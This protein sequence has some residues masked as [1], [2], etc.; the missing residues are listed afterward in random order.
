MK[1]IA[2]GGSTKVHWLLTDNDRRIQEIFT[3]GMNPGVMDCAAMR[4]LLAAHLLPALGKNAD[5]I[6]SVEYYGAGCRGEASVR[7]RELLGELLPSARSIIV[8]SDM[9]GACRGVTKCEKA[10]VCILGTGTNSCLYDGERIIENVPPLG[11]ILGDEGSGAWLGKRLVADTLKGLLPTDI[12]EAFHADY[13]YSYDELIRHIYRPTA[14]DSTPNSFLASFAPFLSF[15]IDC[16]EIESIVL[17]GFNLFFDRNVMLY[18]SRHHL[19]SDTPIY[20]I[21]SVAHSF[22]SQL[23][24]VADLHGLILAGI[25]R[26]PLSDLTNQS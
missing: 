20:F 3:P 26:S 9:T 11:Y 2:D 13:P 4:Q 19:P 18:F 6:G 21:G 22:Q 10:V 15:H 24:Q 1:L 14:E 7:L 23:K 17:E 5:E 25:Y 16:P 8:D 12:T